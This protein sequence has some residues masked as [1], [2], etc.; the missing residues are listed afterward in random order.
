MQKYY[1]PE[2]IE[3]L[4]AELR[5]AKKDFFH[6]STCKL[7][8]QP[9]AVYLDAILE[10]KYANLAEICEEITFIIDDYFKNY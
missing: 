9:D 5:E 4:A 3:R 1:N 6:L 8:H 2:E 10:D 7:A